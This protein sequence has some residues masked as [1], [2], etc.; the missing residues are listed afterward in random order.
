VKSAPLAAQT[1]GASSQP[2]SNTG[3]ALPR[4]F[5]SLGIGT[6]LTDGSF[7]YIVIFPLF[8]ET[9]RID[10][11]VDLGRHLVFDIGGGLRLWKRL[12]MG[13]SYVTATAD[14]TL[15][16]EITLPNPFLFDQPTTG[17]AHG[18]TRQTTRQF[19]IEGLFSLYR[20]PRWLV[21]LSGGPALTS[22]TQNLARDTFRIEYTFPFETIDVTEVS[23]DDSSGTA[24]GGHVG[25]SVTWT[26]GRRFGLD[27]RIRWSG[28]SV[29][30]DDIDGNRVTVEAGGLQLTG[31]IRFLF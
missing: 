26:P 22:L 19:L 16:S 17:L 1:P 7:D 27:G 2:P 9:G 4:G 13:A 3:Q 14:G 18:S 8:A 10:T 5:V 31:G 23:G 30:L 6:S 24:Y 28:A 11:T 12:G 25:L 15:A 21:V 29:D 20:S